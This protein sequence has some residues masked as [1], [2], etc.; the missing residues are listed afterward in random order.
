MKR[1]FVVSWFYPP[2]NSSE[3]LVTARLLAHTKYPCDVFTQA[4]SARWSYGLTA[5]LP[6]ADNVRRIEAKADAP[7]AFAEEAFRY[8]QARRDAYSLVMTRSMPPECHAAGLAIKR[9]FPEIPW[10]ASF[11]DPIKDNP[12]R[13]L[14]ESLFSRWSVLSLKNRNA[15]P[16]FCL[17][18]RRAA[19]ELLW[20]LRHRAALR[21]RVMLSDLEDETIQRADR[22][23]V[24]NR[25]ELRFL[26]PDEALRDKA[27]LL[28]HSYDPAL[29]EDLPRQR[30]GGK[31][32]FVFT[33]TLDA[34]RSACPLLEAIAE[35]KADTG[36]LEERAEFL[37]FGTMAERDLAA[38]V[39][40]GLTALVR[41]SPPISYADSLRQLSAADWAVHIDADL[42]EVWHENVFFAAKLSDY[43]GAHVPVFAIGMPSGDV[44]RCLERAGMVTVGFSVG[45]IKQALYEILYL[46]RRAVPDWDW[47][48]SEFDVRRTAERLDQV[49]TEVVPD[50]I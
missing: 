26:L 39:R 8:F 20:L 24:N 22:I 3:G 33:G 16:G 9:A 27:V 47:I 50:G 17:S 45:E 6:T 43:F 18:P 13:H 4:A 35:L 1:I 36:D 37:F 34:L 14:D 48:A 5:E 30:T 19:H 32:R 46:G 29:Y 49:I 11:G 44:T 10:L 40:L 12:Y 38:I 7:T 2:L 15:S 31:T 42:S 41:Y 25:S 21:E 23:L 28:R